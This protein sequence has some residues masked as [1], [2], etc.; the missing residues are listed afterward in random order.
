[1]QAK[2]SVPYLS[3][4]LIAIRLLTQTN[5]YPNITLFY[6]TINRMWGQWTIFCARLIRF[7][8]N[9]CY[10]QDDVKK[11]AKHQMSLVMILLSGYYLLSS[12]D[13]V[14]NV[15]IRRN[16]TLM[17]QMIVS[18]INWWHP[19]KMKMTFVFPR[20]RWKNSLKFVMPNS[21]QMDKM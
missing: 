4:L 1:M 21:V 7:R 12:E 11:Y 15:V 16:I 13:K 17:I 18:V 20:S 6:N 2:I 5:K 9:I 3:E 10:H 19:V 8:S 14:S